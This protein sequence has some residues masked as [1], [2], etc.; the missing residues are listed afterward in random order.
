M[1]GNRVQTFNE[2]L[3][4]GCGGDLILPARDYGKSRV[5]WLTAR[6]SG[7]GAS[8]TATILGLNPWRTPLDVWLEKTGPAPDGDTELNEAAAWGNV[9]EDPVARATVKRHPDLG[10]LV[11]TPGLLRH[12]EHH[13]MLATLDRLLAP[14]GKRGAAVTSALEVKTTS[15]M[16]YRHNWEEGVPPGYILVQVQQQLAVADLPFG[17]VT[18]LAGGQK[19]AEPFRVERDDRVVEQLVTYAGHWWETHI[20]GG[21]RPE[22]TFADRDKMASLYPADDALDAVRMTDELEDALGRF[23]HAKERIKTAEADKETAEFQLQQAMGTRTAI[24]DHDGEARLTWKQQS[25][26]RIDSKRLRAERPNIADEYTNKSTTRVMRVK[27]G[28]K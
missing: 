12:P 11:P 25:S 5:G 27:K 26:S 19:L 8:E 18:C 15:D 4:K 28:A 20:V 9:L 23:V 7:L 1:R 6:R 3:P 24:K 16:N 10:K 22:P 21:V 13:W 2:L 17:W 14:R